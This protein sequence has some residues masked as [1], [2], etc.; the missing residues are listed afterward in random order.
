MVCVAYM[1]LAVA[2]FVSVEVVEGLIA[3]LGHRSNIAVARIVSV[4]DVTVIAV[5]AVIPG[6]SSDE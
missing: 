5:V 6:A 1:A 2:C 4:V 3:M